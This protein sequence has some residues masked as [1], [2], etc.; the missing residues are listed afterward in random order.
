MIAIDGEQA[1]AFLNTMR[2]GKKQLEWLVAREQ[3]QKTPK[4]KIMVLNHVSINFGFFACA[5]LVRLSLTNSL[6]CVPH[7]ISDRQ[8]GFV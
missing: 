8:V 5:R 3:G 1:G 4:S 2:L 6:Q 7:W